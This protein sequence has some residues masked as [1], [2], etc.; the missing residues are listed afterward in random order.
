MGYQSYREG[1]MKISSVA[2]LVNEHAMVDLQVLF[3]TLEL[4]NSPPPTL[5]VYTDTI[6]D[7]L[8]KKLPYSGKVY[9]RIALDAYTGLNRREMEQRPGKTFKSL[10]ADFCAEK[11][12]LIQWALE[13]SPEG[14]LF[15]DA[16]ICHLGPLPTVPDDTQI[17]LSRHMIRTRDEA[18]YGQFNAGF[19]FFK[20]SDLAAQWLRACHTSR[21]FE[22]ACL[23]DLAD[24]SHYE[25]PIQNN[26]G[27]WR[28]FQSDQTPESLKA[29]WSFFRNETSSGLSVQKSPVLSIHTHWKEKSDPVTITFNKFVLENLKK[30]TSLKKTRALVH[31]IESVLS[32]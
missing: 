22:Q 10:F 24:G 11:P 14:V 28:M 13:S 32:A 7:T 30:L 21:F 29:A 8:V 9:T 31:K 19:L 18:K 5:Y 25:F 20:R 17:G 27:W 12:L 23:E 2:T 6:T 3:F 1:F 26:Y 16:D 15:N 4:W